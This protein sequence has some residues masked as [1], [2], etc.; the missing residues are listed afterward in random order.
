MTAKVSPIGVFSFCRF[1]ERQKRPTAADS[2][3]AP[4]QHSGQHTLRQMRI[5]GNA[6]QDIERKR[7]PE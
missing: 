7:Q 1:D 5:Q 3:A 2:L 6:D 4:R